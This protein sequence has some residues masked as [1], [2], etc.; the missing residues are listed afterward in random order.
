[1]RKPSSNLVLQS[2]CASTSQVL[3]LSNAD[4]LAPLTARDGN[5][6]EE[7]GGG[8]SNSFKRKKNTFRLFFW[9]LSVA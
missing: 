4:S 6:L 8:L 3:S 7:L 9:C 1:M 5:I 2:H